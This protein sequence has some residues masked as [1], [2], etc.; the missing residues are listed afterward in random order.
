MVFV[1]DIPSS[2]MIPALV[3]PIYQAHDANVQ[4]RDT[5]SNGS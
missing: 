1:L 3:E 2:V 5:S 4:R